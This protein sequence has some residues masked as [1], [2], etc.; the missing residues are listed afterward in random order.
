[1][2]DDIT[3]IDHAL[4]RPWV[5][6]KTYRRVASDKP[7]WFGHKVC[8]EG[9]AHVGIGKEVYYLSGDGLSDAGREGPAAARSALFQEIRSL[10]SRGIPGSD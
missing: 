3:T 6:N 7:I 1:M 4:T 10:R 2:H 8:G 9:N 5:V